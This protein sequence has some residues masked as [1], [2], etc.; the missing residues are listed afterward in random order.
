MTRTI[1]GS[2][3]E[4]EL[5]G[6]SAGQVPYQSAADTTDFTGP[7]TAGQV[8]TSTGGSAPTFQTL[9]PSNNLPGGTAGQVVYQSAPSTT[10]FTG[11]GTSGQV[12]TSTG[13]SAPTFQTL[14]SV[15]SAT[16]ATNLAAGSGGQV[17]FQSASGTTGFTGPGTSGQILTSTGGS[18]PTFQTLSSVP[19]STTATNL[20][21]G[22]AGQVPFQSSSG[23]TSFTGP[24]TSG[25]VL[26]SGGVS[27][28]TYTTITTV[29]SANN[30]TGGSAGLVLYQSASGVTSGAGPGTA[31]QVL[32]S[33]GATAPTF[34]TPSTTA[35]NLAGGTTGQ[36]VYQSGA[37]ATAFT[38]P[39]TAGQVLTSNGAAAP[40][41]QAIPAASS[42]TNLA[43]GTAFNVPYQSA[44]GTTAFTSTTGVSGLL[45]RSNAGAPPAFTAV[46]TTFTIYANGAGTYTTP[47]NC[48]FITVEMIGGG[49]GGG[50]SGS[51]QS[52]Y[53]GGGAAGQYY[54]LRITPGSYSY[55]VGTGGAGAFT[56]GAFE[57]NG[58]AG[59]PTV[60]GAATADG[61]G[62]GGGGGPS[63]NGAGGAPLSGSTPGSYTVLASV[64]GDCGYCNTVGGSL[65]VPGGV[66]FYGKSRGPGTTS[67]LPFGALP[68]APYGAGGSGGSYNNIGQKGGDG[69]SGR[70]F[71][72][73]YY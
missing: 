3:Q 69:G 29:P 14:S 68:P 47:T 23:V 58:A 25:Q 73:E 37:G 7:G 52:S 21:S 35:S 50:V 20:A 42:A 28:P 34:Q 2:T 67:Q 61:G 13:G 51:G 26:T 8:L 59:A 66:S 55:S 9:P 18:A 12:L 15:P 1:D 49:G 72:T 30:I 6:G 44:V 33:N 10:T 17:P 22:T 63:G 56:G 40:T 39:G 64:A 48:L 32:T 41:Y 45:L 60:F 54:L 70:I 46:Y 38:G 27:G 57:N 36:V 62:G 5:S 43:G 11:P 53:G 71:I 24:G 19:S 31:G 4:G 65:V 16:T